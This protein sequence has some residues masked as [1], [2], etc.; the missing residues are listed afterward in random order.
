MKPALPLRT[1][2]VSST[3]YF[4]KVPTA[5]SYLLQSPTRALSAQCRSRSCSHRQS[6][7]G[8]DRHKAS[9]SAPPFEAHPQIGRSQLSEAEAQSDRGSDVVAL[10]KAEGQSAIHLREHDPG[11]EIP[12]WCKPPI[13]SGRDPVERP[14]AEA[15]N[16]RLGCQ[17]PISVQQSPP[18]NLNATA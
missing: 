9:G 15:R 4:R 8:P 14:G 12:L 10:E 2:I 13:D 1:D 11:I 7:C 6:G 16:Q 3:R 5:D 17:G 18:T